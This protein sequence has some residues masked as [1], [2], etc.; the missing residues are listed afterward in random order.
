[1]S[2]RFVEAENVDKPPIDH[3]HS[4]A[5]LVSLPQSPSE[6]GLEAMLSISDLE[7][8]LNS[9]RAVARVEV[10]RFMDGEEI[11]VSFSTA[12]LVAPGLA[13]TSWHSIEARGPHE[14]PSKPADLE[15]Q[16]E[17]V[18]LVFD[19]KGKDS[20]TSYEVAKVE[21]YSEVDLL[22]YALLRLKDRDDIPLRD[23]SYLRF[24]ADFQPISGA[25]LYI[26]QHP[27]GHPQYAASGFLSEPSRT[28][29]R[30][31]YDVPT[32]QGT[33]GAPVL[34]FD[35]WRVIALHIGRNEMVQGLRE[36][37]SLSALIE[38]LYRNR[39]DLHNEIMAAQSTPQPEIV[40]HPSSPQAPSIDGDTVNILHI[41]D[42]LMQAESEAREY[43]V[44]LQADLTQ[45]LG[46]K[47]LDYLVISGNITQHASPQQFNCAFDLVERIVK[48]FGPRDAD[49]IIVVPGNHDVD[50]Q[51]SRDSYRFVYDDELTEPLLDGSFIPA[52]EEG[53]L[54]RNE[55]RYQQRFVAFG[56]HFYDKLYGKTTYPLDYAEQ[57]ILHFCP[58]DRILFLAL[59]SAWEID[60]HYTRR[61][62]I[63]TEALYR[64]LS[65]VADDQ[66]DGWIKIAVWNHSIKTFQSTDDGF[67]QLL[68]SYGFLLCLHGHVHDTGTDFYQYAP[69]SNFH[70]IGAGI[71]GKPSAEDLSSVP[72][73]YNLLSLNRREHTLTVETRKKEHPSAAW[74]ADA[75]WGD[76][77]NPVA[78]YTID[79]NIGARMT[80]NP[81]GRVTD[82]L[83]E[84][85]STTFATAFP[86]TYKILRTTLLDCGLFNSNIELRAVFVDSRISRWRRQVPQEIS[87]ARRVDAIVDLFYNQYNDRQEN[88]L[89]LFL[90][91]LSD[92][93]DPRDVCHRRLTELA[94]ELATLTSRLSI[95]RVYSLEEGESGL[96]P[97][98][99]NQ[100]RQILLDCG[101][102][103]SISRLRNTF[104]DS[105]LEAWRH[106]I[107][108]VT[109]PASLV[110]V[111]IDLLHERYN[112]KQENA[113][114]L[115]L[116]VLS[117][118]ADASSECHESLSK[119]ADILA[120]ETQSL[121]VPEIT[122]MEQSRD[123]VSSDQEDEKLGI[124]SHGT[125]RVRVQKIDGLVLKDHPDA[126]AQE[127]G[128]V[129]YGTVLDVHED[130]EVAK[131]KIGTYGEWLVVRDLN[132]RQGYVEAWFLTPFGSVDLADQMSQRK[133]M[134]SAVIRRTT[135]L[136]TQSVHLDQLLERILDWLISLMDEINLAHISLINE[137]TNELEVAAHQSKQ[138]SV[139][140]KRIPMG[141]GIAGRV[142]R[143]KESLIIP[144]VR[145]DEQ[146]SPFFEDTRSEMA[147]PILRAQNLL[148]VIGIESPSVAAFSGSDT[149]L[150]ESLA[151]LVATAIDNDNARWREL[152]EVI[153]R[154]GLSLAEDIQPGESDILRLIFTQASKLMDT[155]NMYIAL[156]DTNTD[157]VSF[158]LAYREGML[159]NTESEA[160]WQPRRAGAGLTEWIIHNQ[161]PLLNR[162]RMESEEWH[163]QLGR[164]E[165]IGQTF[166]C[167][168]GVPM[169]AKGKVLGVIASYHPTRE[170]VYDE[171]DLQ[172]LLMLASYGAVA[173]DNARISQQGLEISSEMHKL[174]AMS[175][176]T[177]DF[178]HRMSNLAGTIPVRINLIKEDLGATRL[179]HPRLVNLLDGIGQDTQALLGAAQQI[180]RS[181]GDF[182]QERVQITNIIE[183]AIEQIQSAYPDALERVRM[184]T[185]LAVGLS[186][187]EVVKSTLLN[188]LINIIKNALD[189]MP[190]GG[191]LDI[192]AKEI[193]PRNGKHIEITI[194][195]TGIGI[196]PDDLPRVFDLFYTT[197]GQGLGLGL[198]K[199]RIF[200]RQIGG[201]ISIHSKVG[202]GTTVNI[203]IPIE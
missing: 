55:D 26:I 140:F 118:W 195:D 93:K 36:G 105:R 116:R 158:G 110:R 193:T 83:S 12:W 186:E 136:I 81:L 115:F 2:D 191:D 175:Q 98:L 89:A 63:N 99:Y 48:R 58:E 187:I 145:Q 135:Q 24:V 124:E 176:V 103:D 18:R 177:M 32:Q 78:R 37:V 3:G 169:I 125:F 152:R 88:A 198:W 166:A 79:L 44:Q 52:G 185:E 70:F 149:E 108:G 164:K 29:G 30:I 148:G 202:E 47:E 10:T 112:D 126:H 62:G 180:K 11:G 109:D 150:V 190:S 90:Q 35:D 25:S 6:R 162:N 38:D 75:R 155:S 172:L 40:E 144:D 184:K 189:A 61:A 42:M 59:N 16:I 151:G 31:L 43:L 203:S 77:S 65:V 101:P 119:W 117:D 114:V 23:R 130:P 68:T 128:F 33:S 120:Q 54:L 107:P 41:S 167:W 143:S 95:E 46:V 17:Q 181:A 199:D 183:E 92:Q 72:L 127:I 45:K 60:H 9:A 8:L 57:G 74:S 182:P 121:Q 14:P 69:G 97:D 188:S 157:T 7:N 34:R 82:D 194:S 179:Q 111:T 22:D 161:Q 141:E 137:S 71:F 67:L 102:F 123:G 1:M 87:P 20:G 129:P 168:I 173:I 134:E 86:D 4:A 178:A 96:A 84:P 91:V 50:Y 142:T 159:V 28:A 5:M 104:V 133:Q 76:K 154:L 13:L 132:D 196:S 51:V 49:K 94:G 64:A 113:L 147:T 15:R 39:P 100:L 66:Y 156:Y 27:L 197:K 165:Y 174:A 146:C 73:H 56:E 106:E 80:E 200:I 171:D 201:D 19:L 131:V 192:V 160:G 139:R 85:S 53:K 170:Y 21:H 163:R 122:R 153:G 138:G